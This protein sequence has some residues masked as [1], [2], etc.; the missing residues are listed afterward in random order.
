M[1]CE[2]SYCIRMDARRRVRNERRVYTF[3]GSQWDVGFTRKTSH[4]RSVYR[5]IDIISTSETRKMS[6]VSSFQRLFPNDNIFLGNCAWTMMSNGKKFFFFCRTKS[7][8]MGPRRS[9]GIVTAPGTIRPYAW[10]TVEGTDVDLRELSN[11]ICAQE[12]R[13]EADRG[14]VQPA[15]LE[16]GTGGPNT[17]HVHISI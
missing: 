9:I 8:K 3:R 10:K 7:T 5:S 14:P 13:N 12:A 2:G 11:A 15:Q 17:G 4:N 6:L 1:L 16:T